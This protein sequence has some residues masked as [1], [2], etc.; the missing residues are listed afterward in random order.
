M[1]YSKIYTASIGTYRNAEELRAALNDGGCATGDV[2]DLL[3]Q[4]VLSPVRKELDL[5]VVTVE[6]LG[7]AERVDRKEIYDRARALN[8]D[9]CPAEVGPQLWLQHKD[10]INEPQLYI[11]MEPLGD[12]IFQVGRYGP[13]VFL[14]YWSAN[15]VFYSLQSWAFIG[16]PKLTVTK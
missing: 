12:K 10:R 2:D 14:N 13:S 4:V 8:L 11:G 7:L 16:P 6:D 1:R 15:D 3:S 5:M 9:L